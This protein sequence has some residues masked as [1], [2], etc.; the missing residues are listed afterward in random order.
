MPDTDLKI[1]NE[2]PPASESDWRKLLEKDLK[3]RPFEKL[4]TRSLEG[5]DIEPLYSPEGALP[6]D[7]AGFPGAPP[8][9]RGRSDS[10]KDSGWAI[11][12]EYRHPD[13]EVTGREIARDLE[14]GASAVWLEL[15]LYSGVRV[16]TP[17]DLAVALAPIDLAATPVF[18]E[19]GDYGFGAASLLTVVAKKRSVT[20]DRL[21]GGFGIDPLGSL[22]GTGT[23]GG[24]SAGAFRE[25]FDAMKFAREEAP[26]MRAGL[27]STAP[28]REAGATAIQELAYALAT[29]IEYLRR[30]VEAG[31][32]VDAIGESLV[33]ATPVGGDFFLEIA[34]LRAA[35]LLFSKAFGAAGARASAQIPWIHARTARSTKTR[36]D[37]WVNMLRGTAEAFSAAVGGADSIAVA[38]FDAEIGASD[39]LGRRVARNTQL[40]LREESHLHRV[41]DPAGGSFYVE[42]L[43][44]ELARHAWAEMQSIEEAGGMFRAIADGKIARAIAGVVKERRR[45]IAT[46]RAPIVGVSEFP[47]LAEKGLTRPTPDLP[48]IEASLGR[49]LRSVDEDARQQALLAFAQ[50]VLGR[51]VPALGEVSRAAARALESEVDLFSLSTVLRSGRAS[52]HVAPLATDRAASAWEALRHASDKW[53]RSSGRRPRAFLANLG[54]IPEHR[55]RAD[56]AYNLLSAAGIEPLSNDGFATIEAA[57]EAFATSGADLAVICGSDGQYATLAEPLARALVAK[58][59]RHVVLAGRPGENED[60]WRAAGVTLFVFTGADVLSAME[61]LLSSLGVVQ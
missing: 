43:T 53:M 2:F 51:D 9:T 56:F 45:A 35:R 10:P 8:F 31:L 1:A 29:A 44:E 11:C 52:L 57:A 49:L 32:S 40:V 5:I 60:A 41:I 55:A 38:P 39:E 3:G 54:S 27:I 15:G 37:P 46:R 23:L 25:L 22:V 47:D 30:G 58:G 6:P 24:G 17:G 50:T 12:Q 59:A 21:R 14:R 20:P 18:L 16:L 26:G 7:V 28:Y 42:R 61:G 13:V 4:R 48:K 34:K 33:L 36:R 19:G